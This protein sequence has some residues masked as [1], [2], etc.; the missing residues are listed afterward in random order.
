MTK[1][2]PTIKASE[3]KQGGFTLLEIILTLVISAIV[4]TGLVQY[5]G[6]S[7]TKSSVA[8]QRA[9]QAYE[10]QQVMEDITEDYR[11]NFS[12]NLVG[13]QNKISTYDGSYDVVD[14]DTGFIS[15]AANNNEI[16]TD[17]QTLLKVTIKDDL[18]NILTTLFSSP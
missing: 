13:L 9:K 16:D 18:G 15:F 8:I 2:N 14:G 17:T 4:A 10:L 1:L 7:L 3:N 6:T 12:S 11:E 5:L